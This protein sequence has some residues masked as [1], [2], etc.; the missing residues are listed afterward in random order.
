MSILQMSIQAGVLIIAIVV[1]RA[2]ALNRLPQNMFLALW[3]V[4]I[5]RLLVPLSFASR[6]SVYMLTG[7][8]LE[9]TVTSTLH[10]PGPTPFPGGLQLIGLEALDIP[11]QTYVIG[12]PAFTIDPFVSVW[13]CGM[14][15]AFI[16][17]AVLYWRNCRELRFA[18]IV[19]KNR[20]IDEWVNTHKLKRSLSVLQMD[21][22]TTP[23]TA[24]IFRPRIILPKTMDIKDAPLTNYILTHEYYHIRRFD[25]VWKML[26]TLVL[27]IHWFNPLVWVMVI[28]FNRDL[29]IT[30]DEMVVRH[31]GT[32]T[33]TAYA[34]SLISMAEHRSKLAPFYSGF[35]RNAVEERI[36]AI[37]KIKKHSLIMV[38]ISVMIVAGMTAVFVTSASA[39]NIDLIAANSGIPYTSEEYDKLLS[40]QFD[41]YEDM[42]IAEYQKKVIEILE[43]S[44]DYPGLILKQMWQDKDFAKM[45]YSNKLSS[46]Y[47]DTLMPILYLPQGRFFGYPNS[48]YATQGNGIILKYTFLDENQLTVGE[49]SQAM[50]GFINDLYLLLESK[51]VLDLQDE[52]KTNM[53]IWQEIERIKG[54]WQSDVLQFEIEYGDFSIIPFGA[55]NEA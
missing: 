3:G 1:V 21:G 51:D 22:L 40:L 19:R 5:I 25:A 38:L 14:L 13:L 50:Q 9:H 12:Q 43:N 17:F 52:D 16:F 49:Y 29:E 28:M 47:F 11:T 46:F 2:I 4:V 8:V 31:F 32:V 54:N 39:Q 41:G 55:A 23:I 6:F 44:E 20:V 18:Y 30:C 24:G 34:Y 37:M 33:K 53:A 35:S 48:A 10:Q 42:S 15:A 27:C 26:V 45:R 36:T 7:N